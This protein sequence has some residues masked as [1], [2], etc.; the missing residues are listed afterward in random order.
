MPILQ[1][2]KST[3]SKSDNGTITSDTSWN[4]IE[5]FRQVCVKYAGPF[6]TKLTKRVS[7]KRYLCLFTCSTTRAV[8]LEMARS[9][10]TT[11][12]LNAFSRMVATRGKPEEVTSDNGT[13]FFDGDR[14]LRELLEAV[15]KER[16]CQEGVDQG[17]KWNWNPSL[18]SHFG[19]VFEALVKVGKRVLKTIVGNT[20]LSDDELN[21]SVK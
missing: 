21:T 8:H 5:S 6:V 4:I 19:G 13:N 16:I 2:K 7:I 18:G 17:L 9:L 3:I 12:F 14:A 11:D 15:N 1:V 20:G 10:S